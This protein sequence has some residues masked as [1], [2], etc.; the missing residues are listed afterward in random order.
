MH[1]FHLT[2]SPGA[3]RRPPGS[4]AGTRPARAVKDISCKTLLN[5][6]VHPAL[7]LYLVLKRTQR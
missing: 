5:A 1:V 3:V 6:L 4:T 7:P 2:L